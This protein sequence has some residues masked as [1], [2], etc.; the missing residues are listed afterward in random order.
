MFIKY[1]NGKITIL[2]VYV[3]DIVVTGDNHEEM[4]RL[5]KYLVTQF[6]IKN[7]GKV[8]YFLGTEVARS[9]N[10]IFLS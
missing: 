2:I 7:L 5:K 4:A 8:R 3:D 1:H 10:D 9:K 6:K